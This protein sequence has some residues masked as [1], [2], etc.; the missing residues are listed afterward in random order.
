MFIATAIVVAVTV[1]VNLAIV[2]AD[3]ARASF[4][5]ANAEEVDVPLRWI[6]MLAF[7]KGAGA[8]ALLLWFIS[9]PVLPILGAA[10]LVGFFVV[11]VGAHVRAGVF[12][13]IAFPGAFLGLAIASLVLIVVEGA[14]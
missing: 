1:A 5:L 10:G 3:V 2:I 12:Y 7:L 11:A 8:A 4:V 13:N 6:P 9:V 14:R